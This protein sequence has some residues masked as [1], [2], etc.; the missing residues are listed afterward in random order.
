MSFASAL[1]D[2]MDQ[3]E[4]DGEFDLIEGFWG[5]LATNREG[6]VGPYAIKVLKVTGGADDRYGQDYEFAL[7]IDG[8]TDGGLFLAFVDYNSYEYS[9]NEYSLYTAEPYEVTE[10]RYKRL[11]P[12]R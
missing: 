8:G 3:W 1:A 9:G 11:A 12:A 2:Q 4:E 5:D 7:K 6:V 10:T